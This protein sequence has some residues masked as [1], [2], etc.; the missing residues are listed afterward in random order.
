MESLN[1]YVTNIR[2]SYPDFADLR[3]QNR[4]FSGLV[5]WSIVT[6]GIAR[7]SDALPHVKMGAAVS[8][9]FF[10]V[11]GVQPALGRAFRPEDQVPGR[12]AV[13]VSSHQKCEQD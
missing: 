3:K 7:Q 4:S 9:D 5:A 6:A 12:D 8:G 10:D 2:A 1:S 11:L 13:V